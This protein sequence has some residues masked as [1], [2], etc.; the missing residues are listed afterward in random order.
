MA[1][2]QDYMSSAS[3]DD[4]ILA[5]ILPSL[6]APLQPSQKDANL[7]VSSLAPN[8][9][10]PSYIHS[11]ARELCSLVHS[12]AKSEPEIRCCICHHQRNVNSSTRSSRLG[13]RFYLYCPF[14][15]DCCRSLF[16]T[17]KHSGAPS[18]CMPVVH[19][20]VVCHFHVS[21]LL[22]KTTRFP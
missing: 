7:A 20:D 2:I 22:I 16:L 6:L 19:K 12:F 5:F 14:C 9:F 4:G 21:S 13:K 18:Q 17:T 15:Q 3:L 8:Y 1:T 11:L 10:C